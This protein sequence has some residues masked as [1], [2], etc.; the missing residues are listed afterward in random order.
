M[1]ATTEL[2]N[3][4]AVLS[5]GRDILPAAQ[6]EITPL[7]LPGPPTLLTDGIALGNTIVAW[8]LVR[9]RADVSKQATV[10]KVV[11]VAD[12]ETY[13]VKLD[14]GTG[15]ESHPINSGVSATKTTILQAL[16]DSINISP[17]ST[18]YTA[19]LDAAPA[20]PVLT[21][22]HVAV[23]SYTAVKNVT[24]AA[25]MSVDP[26]AQSVTFRVWA[27]PK[28]ETSWYRLP[29]EGRPDPGSDKIV[30][31]NNYMER[32]VVAGLQR[33]FVEVVNTDGTVTPVIA[34]SIEE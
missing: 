26:E 15:V 30:V 5:Q 19:S 7:T 6:T 14:D 32:L 22:K 28:V 8:I 16:A 25:D 17:G 12:S 33:L 13:E 3:T 21:I 11:S 27:L 20:D 34:P 1:M 2:I 29:I 4:L 10:V 23:P 24:G 9:L 31:A 18:L